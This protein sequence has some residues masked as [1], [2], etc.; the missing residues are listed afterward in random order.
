MEVVRVALGEGI[1][2]NALLIIAA[3]VA[4]TEDC[5]SLVVEVPLEDATPTDEIVAEVAEDD[6]SARELVTDVDTTA[7]GELVT[8][9]DT[10]A[11]GDELVTDVGTTA[12]GDELVTDVGTTAEGDELVVDASAEVFDASTD[13]EDAA[14]LVVA[15]V[16]VGVGSGEETE[17]STP[18]VD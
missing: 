3:V 16:K 13:V 1:A 18:D 4:T 5:A 7:E 2:T 15:E 9:V 6:T 17:K 8:D 14:S 10:T 12:E 11:E